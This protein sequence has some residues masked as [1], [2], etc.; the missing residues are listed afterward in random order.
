VIAKCLD[1]LYAIDKECVG[2]DKIPE[3]ALSKRDTACL[4]AAILYLYCHTSFAYKMLQL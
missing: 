4:A 2:R 1:I 3:W